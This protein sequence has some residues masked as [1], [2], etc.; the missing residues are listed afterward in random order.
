MKLLDSVNGVA[1][2]IQAAVDVARGKDHPAAITVI[3]HDWGP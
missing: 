1:A 2:Y 3:G